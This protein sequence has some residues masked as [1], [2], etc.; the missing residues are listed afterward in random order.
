[1]LDMTTPTQRLWL[2]GPK[3]IQNSLLLGYLQQNINYSCAIIDPYTKADNHNIKADHLICMDASSLNYERFQQTLEWLPHNNKVFFINLDSDKEHERLLQ[4]PN[5]CGFFYKGDSHSH[6]SQGLASIL[7]GELW[8]SRKLLSSFVLSNRKSPSKIPDSIYALTKREKQ[9]LNLSA[10]GAK[11]A[12]IAAALNVSTHT[13][14][15]H[16]YNLFKKIDV[17]NRIQAINWAKEYL[18]A[19][20]V[21]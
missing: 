10:S 3:N 8:F 14:K 9:I 6:I 2:I 7:K 18:P 4:W 19:Q 21:A 1:M 15:T 17:S 13:V 16:M 5:V 12:E 11:N 20:D